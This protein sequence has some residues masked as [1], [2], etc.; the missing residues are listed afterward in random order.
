MTTPEVPRQPWCLQGGVSHSDPRSS[1]SFL[2]DLRHL[3][4]LVSLALV[5][6]VRA[7]LVLNP[8]F[9]LQFILD[10]HF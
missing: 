8:S 6:R 5:F 3:A 4:V 1:E 7:S 10:T 9:K 2:G